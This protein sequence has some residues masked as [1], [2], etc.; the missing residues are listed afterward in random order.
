MKFVTFAG[1]S[2]RLGVL[3]D[4][5]TLF[6]LTSAWRHADDST[7]PS[8]VG[9][10][11]A[12]GPDGLREVERLLREQAG[13]AAYTARLADTRLLAP[14]PRPAKNIFC[15]G[16]NYREHI[17]EGNRAR[18]RDPH[19]FPKVI[20]VFTKP[21]TT[22]I[23]PDAA[24]AAHAD[25]TR[26]L[27]YEVELGVVIG[28]A[29]INIPAARAMDH[30][31]GY[32]IINDISARDLQKAHGQWFKGKALDS[33]CPMGPCIVHKQAID[34]PHALSIQLDVNGERRQD[35]NT[36]DLLFKIPDIIAQLSAGMTL[37]AGDIIATG[38][39]SGVGLGL[40]PPRYLRKGD[41]VS[42]RIE[43]LGVLRNTIGD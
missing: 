32:T 4:P 8:D 21:P 7:A 19:D 17:V 30:V 43:G 18:G 27:D 23:G 9:D 12:L 20:E 16:R 10:L 28:K 39:P 41:V 40:V 38:T 25:V 34:D 13:N 35:S 11:I 33:H 29:G 36:A 5:D 14:I 6:D 22:V 2:H 1:S 26:E 42:A 15:I 37:E 24:I 3:L 31:F